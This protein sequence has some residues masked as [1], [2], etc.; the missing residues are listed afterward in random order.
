V[1]VSKRRKQPTPY[2]RPVTT[3]FTN[4]RVHWTNC[5]DRLSLSLSLSSHGFFCRYVGPSY[6]FLHDSLLES[7]CFYLFSQHHFSLDLYMYGFLHPTT[8]I[9]ANY[10]PHHIHTYT[11]TSLSP[12]NL[13]SVPVVFLLLLFFL[14]FIV[15]F[16]TCVIIFFVTLVMISNKKNKESLITSCAHHEGLVIWSPSFPLF[17]FY[18][19]I[20]MRLL[21]FPSSP[22]VDHIF[23]P[24]S[25]L[26]CLALPFLFIRHQ[27]IFY[28][29]PP[30]PQ[31]LGSCQNPQHSGEI[32]SKVD[33]SSLGGSK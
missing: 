8:S 33:G 22:G 4:Q 30:P 1:S 28:Q 26:P 3:R 14:L 11:H 5:K 21:F 25:P 13:S 17:F 23:P 18:F 9:T 27:R 29:I 20:S 15:C 10:L 31:K 19:D 24:F 32:P 16:V 12:H 7:P 2:P 6:F